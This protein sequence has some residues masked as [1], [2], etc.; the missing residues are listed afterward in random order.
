MKIDGRIYAAV[1]GLLV[2][3]AIALFIGKVFYMLAAILATLAL[4]VL[5]GFMQPVKYIGIELVTLSTIFAGIMFGSLAGAVYGVMILL[6]H[7]VLG[8]YYI[9]P[10]LVWLLPEYA[11]LGA[12]AGI[13]GSG[14][15][16]LFGISFI[17][18]M[19]LANLLMT[20]LVDRERT[21]HHLPYVL[22]NTIINSL[23]LVQVMPLLL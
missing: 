5:L 7:L 18:S 13:M 23:L 17:V 2:L 3:A 9:G 11:A 14:I 8:R 15:I 4:A 10:Y 16:G 19:N 20:F 21:A 12:V 1:V 22:G 6:A